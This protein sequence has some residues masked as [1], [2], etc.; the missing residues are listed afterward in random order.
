M[1]FTGE[2]SEI[3]WLY[4]L[5]GEIEQTAGSDPVSLLP[6]ESLAHRSMASVYY[7]SNESDVHITDDT[8]IFERSQ[9]VAFRLVEIYFQTVHPCFPIISSKI[10]V[11]QVK[12]FYAAP[13]GRTG[14]RWLAI[15]NLVFAIAARYSSLVQGSP[16][17][18]LDYKRYFSRARK[19]NINDTALID[20]PNLQQVQ[21]EGLTALYLL[22]VGEINR[23]VVSIFLFMNRLTCAFSL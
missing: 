19:L 9:P 4:R 8:G 2:H 14:K 3:A 1:G 15:L 21:V 20:P 6:K 22:S 13:S 18:Q 16:G 17:Q 5:K 12:D 11:E 23:L 10:F 7:F